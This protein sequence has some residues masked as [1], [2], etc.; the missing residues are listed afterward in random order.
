MG[1]CGGFGYTLWS[2]AVDLVVR[3]GPLQRIL[4]CTLGHCGVFGLRYGPPWRFWLYA[5]GHC[6]RFGYMLWATSADLVVPYGPQRVMKLHSKICIDFSTIGHS[7]GFGYA[8]W[9]IAQSLVIGYGP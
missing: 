4:L 1:H 8:L 3:N 5:M 2:T 9:A 7:A 6:G